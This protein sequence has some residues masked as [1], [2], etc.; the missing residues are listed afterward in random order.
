[1]KTHCPNCGFTCSLDDIIKDECARE[2]SALMIQHANL[3]RNLVLYAGLFSKPTRKTSW[4]KILRIAQ[5]VLAL[6]CD[7]RMDEALFKTVESMREKH[8]DGTF[9]PLTNHRYLSKV[10][11][12]VKPVLNVSTVPS[13][14]NPAVVG[15]KPTRMDSQLSATQ[16]L[17]MDD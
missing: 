4:P 8:S 16:Q 15:S 14:G 11:E 7:E 6:G 12:D 3:Y 17:R 1:M 9:K 13:S 5:E 2:F 10:L